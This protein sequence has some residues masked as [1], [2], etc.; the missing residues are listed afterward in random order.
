ML[1]ECFLYLR[2]VLQLPDGIILNFLYFTICGIIDQVEFICNISIGVHIE[3]VEHNSLDASFAVRP[4]HNEHHAVLRSLG[5]VV[6]A[7]TD[8]VLEAIVEHV[9]KV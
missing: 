2:W 4:E 1:V 3:T 9:V 8:L 5:I 7:V 6:L